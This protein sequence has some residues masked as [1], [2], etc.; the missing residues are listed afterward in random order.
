MGFFSKLKEGL[1]KTKDNIGKKI[2]AAFSG[3]AL[4]DDFYEELEEAMLTADMGVTATEQ[5]LDEFKDEVYREKITDTEKA[6]NLLKRIMV[7]SISYDIPDYDYPLVILLAG[8]N[9]VGKTTAI[10]KL[11]N[12]FKSIG[13]SVVV[14][15]ADT[16]RAAASDQL[17]VWAD[18]ANVRIIK[19]KEGSDPASVVFDAISSAKARGDDVILVDT[20]GRLH[21]KKNLMDELKKIHKVIIRELPNADYRSYIVL[22]ATT[23][24]NALS[25][26]EIFSEAIDIDGIILTK[27]D[28]TAKGGVVMAISAEQE[29]PVVFV[30]VGEKIDDLLPFNPE[31]F[32]DAIFEN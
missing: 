31:E 13:K 16:F 11:A 15:A 4:D 10:G 5:I 20:A 21:N 26:V 30:G 17:E 14:A 28:G 7:D 23:G 24:Q 9:G 18:R 27:L 32:V 19:H 6:K 29:I 3:R 22:D 1:K 25:Q 2:F 12:Y 8:V